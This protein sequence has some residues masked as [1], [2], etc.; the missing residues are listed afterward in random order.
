MPK[1]SKNG[2]FL[3]WPTWV[4]Y[5]KYHIELNVDVFVKK[6]SLRLP[7]APCWLHFGLHFGVILDTFG[8][9]FGDFQ[10]SFM[11][12]F[13]GGLHG[14]HRGEFRRVPGSPGRDK[15]RGKPLPLGIEG[16]K[17]GEKGLRA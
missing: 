14:S 2:R 7:L 1:G 13:F 12:S 15:G 11:R 17:E 3:R 9:R 8:H 4:S 10:A 6:S 16:L 5:G